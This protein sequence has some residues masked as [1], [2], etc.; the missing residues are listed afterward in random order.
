[1]NYFR[2]GVEP[3]LNTTDS[4]LSIRPP[5]RKNIS[6][7]NDFEQIKSKISNPSTFG[8]GIW[9]C[10]HMM[11]RD[12]NNEQKKMKFKEFIEQ[13]IHNLPCQT[14][15][16]HATEYYRSHPLN[17]YWNIKE[18]GEDVGLFK[19]TW[20]FHNAVNNRLNKPYISWENAKMLYSKE[21]GV[22]TSECDGNT[23]ETQ[24]N[25]SMKEDPLQRFIP[26][27]IILPNNIE[28]TKKSNKVRIIG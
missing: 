12:C 16:D 3:L 5:D 11:A 19:W 24:P 23:T 18:H 9:Y 7:N 13:V 20:T 4:N 28:K 27:S 17:D 14:C 22:C 25:I 10:I 8:P 6:T 1:M 26:K 2:S 21:D 15:T